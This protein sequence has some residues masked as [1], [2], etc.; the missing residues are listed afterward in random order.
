MRHCHTVSFFA[1]AL[2]LSADIYDQ[3]QQL[4]GT[5]VP[6][7]IRFNG[8]HHGQRVQAGVVGATFSVYREQYDGTPLWSE[9]QNVQPDKDGNYSILLGSTRTDGMPLDLFATAEPL[10]AGSGG[11]SGQATAHPARQRSLCIEIR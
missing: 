5:A 2:S 7:L 4:K 6:R 1:V 8:S 3:Q 10:L 11:R 9:I